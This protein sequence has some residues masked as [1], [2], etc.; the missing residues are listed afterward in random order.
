MLD[1]KCQ[2]P[3]RLRVL[4]MGTEVR[5]SEKSHTKRTSVFNAIVQ[6]LYLFIFL[7]NFLQYHTL[8]TKKV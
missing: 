6:V 5:Y 2:T 3:N 8:C 4:E 1:I 7:P